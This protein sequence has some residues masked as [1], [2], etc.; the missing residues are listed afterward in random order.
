MVLA[1]LMPPIATCV[2][3]G[4]EMTQAESECCRQMAE[5]CG[6]K[7]MPDSHSC[8]TKASIQTNDAL[9]G[10]AGHTFTLEFTA[11]LDARLSA[12][13]DVEERVVAIFSDV[14]GP[15]GISSRTLQ[16]LRI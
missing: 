5:D 12:P 4:A 11:A 16:A 2:A 10:P 9:L 8:C 14:H 7:D 15:P 6:G 3:A 1:V 13:P